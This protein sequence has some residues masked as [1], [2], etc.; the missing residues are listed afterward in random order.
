MARERIELCEALDQR[1]DDRRAESFNFDLEVEASDD[2]IKLSSL[3]RWWHSWPKFWRI[4][5]VR[6]LPLAVNYAQGMHSLVAKR[7][8]AV[9]QEAILPVHPLF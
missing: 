8:A 5:A 1:I 4:V 2:G 6:A 9:R 3:R 7:R